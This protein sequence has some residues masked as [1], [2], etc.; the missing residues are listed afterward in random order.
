MSAES[1]SADAMDY[2][3][4]TWRASH[5]AEPFSVLMAVYHGD[6]YDAVARAVRSQTVD[7]IL[8][9]SQIVIVRDGPVG[10]RVQEFL[11]RLAHDGLDAVFGLPR[12]ADPIEV[13]VVEL[14]KNRG[15]AAALNIGMDRCAHDIV[16][17]ADADDIAL[18]S[19]FA[20]QTHLLERDAFD[21]VGTAIMEFGAVKNCASLDGLDAGCA[22]EI[23][24]IVASENLQ[25]GPIR[26]IPT[27]SEAL[28]RYARR[29]SPFHHP[30][31]V[32]RVGVLRD[33]FGGYPEAVG[34]FE[35]Y[36]LWIRMIADGV[37][38]GNVDL[39]LVLYR[40][41]DAAFRRRLGWSMFTDEIRLQRWMRRIGFTNLGQYL[42]NIVVRA[43]SRLLPEPVRTAGYHL[44]NAAAHKRRSSG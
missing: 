16:A 27:S 18:P 10:S 39:P 36:A 28:A 19:R 29:R 1:P 38:A 20:Y 26:H 35:D 44:I 17:R 2:P 6:S 32:T 34:R 33:R 21:I 30:T 9:P 15:L 14:D 31:V 41:G 7:Q 43:G 37:R 5:A 13:C 24:Q 4:R 40:V 3:W 23:A 11:D 22:D 8:K 42:A 25:L 12:P